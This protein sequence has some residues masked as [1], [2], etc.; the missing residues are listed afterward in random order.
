MNIDP[1]QMGLA[2]AV[3]GFV[4]GLLF[5]RVIAYIRGDFKTQKIHELECEN[6]YLNRRLNAETQIYSRLTDDLVSKFYRENR[7]QDDPDEPQDDEPVIEY[8]TVVET[9]PKDPRH[10]IFNRRARFNPHHF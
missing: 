9:D 3:Y 4:M 1:L 2:C 10:F 6:E 5:A 7:Y 8:E